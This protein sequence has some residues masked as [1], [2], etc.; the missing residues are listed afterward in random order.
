MAA[1]GDE[2]VAGLDVAMDEARRVR[3]VERGPDLPGDRERA[4]RLEPAF[5]FEEGPQVGRLDVAH[6]DVQDA[7]GLAGVV[8]RDDVRVIEAAAI[9]DSRRKR[10]RKRSLCQRR[11]EHLQRNDSAKP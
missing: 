8:D 4:R 11:G 2:D 3:R 9:R 10:S 1:L 7:V 6:R 5:A